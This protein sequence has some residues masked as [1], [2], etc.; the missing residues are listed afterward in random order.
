[1]GE[2]EA[3]PLEEAVAGGGG[4]P[5]DVQAGEQ[6]VAAVHHVVHEG[7]VA[8]LRLEDGEVHR[9]LDHPVDAG[10]QRDVGDGRVGGIVG[11]DLAV[12]LAVDLH[13][14]AGAAE[15]RAVECGGLAGDL[16]AG[17]LR[18]RSAD[19]EQGGRGEREGQV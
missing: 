16:D 4:A 8:V 1:P 11:V 3:L 14:L 9:V 18:L 15:G 6:L 17:D 19:G 5:A 10:R 12:G 13:V 7:A 2:R